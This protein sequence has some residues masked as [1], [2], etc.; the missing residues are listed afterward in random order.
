VNVQS[1]KKEIVK[2]R[3]GLQTVRSNLGE[4][5]VTLRIFEIVIEMKITLVIVKTETSA[6]GFRRIKCPIIE[7]F[8]W[9]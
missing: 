8:Y 2:L 6:K 4:R 3:Q 9:Y 1:V 7:R 5:L